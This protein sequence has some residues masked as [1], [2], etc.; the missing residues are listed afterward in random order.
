MYATVE[1]ARGRLGETVAAELYITDAV[2]ADD[3]A[4]AAAEIDSAL[5]RHYR[6]PVEAAAA[7]PL[8]KHW[9]LTLMEELAWSRGGSDNIPENVRD[10]VAQIRATLAKYANRELALPG[11]EITGTVAE[12]AGEPRIFTRENLRG[13]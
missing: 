9:N 6:I 8:L 12:V 5:A 3:L 10:R 2:I 1:E 7:L 11:A 13:Y 4:C